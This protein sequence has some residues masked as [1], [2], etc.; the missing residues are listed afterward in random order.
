MQRFF[1]FLIKNIIKFYIVNF[2]YKIAKMENEE[3][4]IYFM[5]ILHINMGP[6]LCIIYEIFKTTK[7]YIE[8]F[9]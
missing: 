1:F 4:N 7:N 2:I 9:I 8:N 3:K 6:N 5:C